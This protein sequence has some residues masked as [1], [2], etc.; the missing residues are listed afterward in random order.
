MTQNNL[1]LHI[2]TSSHLK[3][4]KKYISNTLDILKN[5]GEKNNFKVQFNAINEPS[6]DDIKKNLDEYNKR[7]NFDK[8]DDTEF[9]DTITQLNIQQ[10]SNYEKH[11]NI[12]NIIQKLPDNSFHLILEDDVLVSNDYINNI[13][14]LLLNIDKLK[15]DILFTCISSNND[16]EK[17]IK[18]VD[19]INL[20]KLMFCKSS[21][22][23]NKEIA[24]KLYEYTNTIKYS[25]KNAISK[26]IFNNK[27]IKACILNKHT[28]LEGSKIG[29]FP[30]S[31]NNSNFLYQNNDFVK[32]ARIINNNTNIT[33]DIIK[34]AE[35]IYR[36]N[37]N[38]IT[39]PEFQHSMGILYYKANNYDKSLNYLKDSLNSLKRND[40]LITNQTEILNNCINMHQHCQP[41]IDYLKKPSIYT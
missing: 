17:D 39:N 3:Q 33:E 27:N 2:I 30:T 5:L 15:W 4:R 40:G 28:F 41:D 31:V 16:T 14:D 21:Y 19:S 24:K 10:I 36:L 9:N 7:I 11:R 35:I 37:P 13:E 20:F 6:I 23:I 1:F 12:Y 25:I 38:N 22:F 32:L 34:E 29:V 18:T 8:E 26:F